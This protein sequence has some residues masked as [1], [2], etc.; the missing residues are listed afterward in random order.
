[1]A[2]EGGEPVQMSGEQRLVSGCITGVEIDRR[3]A[4][5]GP[6]GAGGEAD[7]GG[8]GR[9]EN[10]IGDAAVKREENG[11]QLIVCI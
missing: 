7:D 10:G 1:M 11:R 4:S 3:E 8:C 9:V 2:V 5:G 6:T